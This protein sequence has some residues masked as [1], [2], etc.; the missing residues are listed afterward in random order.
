MPDLQ[1]IISNQIG[2]AAA[3]ATLTLEE[4]ITNMKVSGMADIAIRQS[5]LDD[6]SVGG[7]LF[8]G[9]R[10]K[11]RSTVKNGVE[12]SSNSSSNGRFIKAGVKEFKWVS[13]S[14]NKVCPDCKEKHGEV[15]TMEYFEILGLPASGF[16]ICGPNCRCM[17]VPSNYKG[18]NLNRPLVKMPSVTLKQKKDI[19]FKYQD[20]LD[21]FI[22]L[23]DSD[24]VKKWVHNKVNAGKTNHTELYRGMALKNKDIDDFINK[25]KN[26]DFIFPEGNQMQSFTSDI[27]LAES[28]SKWRRTEISPYA[29]ENKQIVMVFTSKQGQTLRGLDINK[30]AMNKTYETQ[31]ETILGGNNKYK[32]IALDET[33]DGILF[34][35]MEQI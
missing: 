10:S 22:S 21:D 24:P 1:L 33:S 4:A 3:Q 31:L 23:P 19:L 17:I 25:L 27:D 16:S 12:Y 28:Y 2:M 32:F 8:G 20:N 13:I 18:E 5:L 6:L 15:G 7:P 9:F 11:L 30:S 29:S 26:E 14:D 35:Q 34:I